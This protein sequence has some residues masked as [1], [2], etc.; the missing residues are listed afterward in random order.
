MQLLSKYKNINIL[1][2]FL[3]YSAHSVFADSL[4]YEFLSNDKLFPTI[5]LDPF[6]CQLMGGL[7]AIN[8]DENFKSDIY[9][10]VN[11]GVT[12][13]VFSWKNELI[14]HEI[15]LEFASY[16]QFEIERIDSKTSLGG[17]MNNDF[18]IGFA[19]STSLNSSLIRL[20][21]FHISSHL[22][23]DYILR[24]DIDKPNDRSQNYE[25]LDITFLRS[26]K[27]SIFY[28]GSGYIISKYAY[29]KRYSAQIGAEYYFLEKYNNLKAFSALDTRILQEDNFS[30]SVR[31]AIGITYHKAEN[32]KLKFW[33]EYYNGFLPYSTIDAGKISWYG[34]G[35]N[36]NI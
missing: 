26:Y 14:K 12:K 10:L 7:Y 11:I 18:R 17:L 3:F 15:A 21:F 13:P 23:D 16:T 22:G 1:I 27:Q 31:Y 8:G 25:Q 33:L 4:Q 35:M 2:L 28:I 30:P 5:V 6:E 32:S 34:L 24:N 20:R 29:R 9:S 36:V 19:A